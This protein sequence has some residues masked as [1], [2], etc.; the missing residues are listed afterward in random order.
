[1]EILPIELFG[2]AIDVPFPSP[3]GFQQARLEEFG[4]KICDSTKGLGLRVDQVRL[5]R[6]DELYGYELNANFFGDNG[7]LVRTAD[8]VKLSVRNA[9]NAA[10]WNLVR[11]TFVRFY[12]LM[13]FLPASI[14]T[15]SSHVH[16]RFEDAGERNRFMEG[17]EHGFELVRPAA[18]GYVRIADWEK[19]IRVLIEQSNAIQDGVFV[20]WDTQFENSQDWESFLY[21]LPT[22]MENA[23][24]LF[25]LG[26]E[27]FKLA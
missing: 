10:D 23:A 27:P 17:F 25:G 2:F 22:M 8:R 13:E 21:T 1:M 11:E 18:L 7:T 9:R 6:S 16:A 26:F 19:E 5:R 3:L 4:A 12:M 20:A 14:S 24:N 15:L